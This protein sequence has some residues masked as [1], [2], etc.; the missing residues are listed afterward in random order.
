MTNM[1]I[2]AF[3]GT[4]NHP[5]VLKS[6]IARGFGNASATYE[7][8][9]RLQRMMGDAMIGRLED[10]ELPEGGRTIVDLGCGTGWFTRALQ[11][12]YPE[13]QITGVDLSPGMIRHARQNVGENSFHWLVADAEAV[14]LPDESVDL[15]FSNLMLQWCQDPRPVLRECRRLLRPGGRLLVST[16]LDGTLWELK[17]AWATADPGQSHVNRFEPGSALRD[18]V[19][20]EL[21]EA[22]V[23]NRV[24]RLP[25]RSP[26]ALV[27]ELKHLGAGFK[28]QD[29]RK[30]ATAPGRLRQMCRQY[31]ATPDGKVEASYEA[32]WIDWQKTP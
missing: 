8:A 5:P 19:L 14:P 4:A 16:L 3:P 29:R 20:A 26:M 32:C 30:T 28:D 6:D 17:Q 11:H 12:H 21:S 18:R 27:S 1:A 31:P 9:S 22:Q 7:S 25:Y 2:T 23:E 15:I 24:L 13:Q 10:W